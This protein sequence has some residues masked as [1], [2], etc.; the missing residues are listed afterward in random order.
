METV[1]VVCGVYGLGSQVIQRTP[2]QALRNKWQIN[3][4]QQLIYVEVASTVQFL[5]RYYSGLVSSISVNAV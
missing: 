2:L 3:W 1:T 4:D 5:A